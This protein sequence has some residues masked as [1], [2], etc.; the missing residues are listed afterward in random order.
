MIT[1]STRLFGI[2]G[3]PIGHVR[4]PMVFNARF[5]RDGIDAV[6]LPFDSRPERFADAVRGL[7][8]LE[9]LGGFIV[10]APHKQAMAALC[11]ELVGE[12]RLV[13]AVNTVRREPDGR[14]VGELFDG[15]G[16][17]EGLKAHG[18]D[19]AGRRLF[20][21]GAGGAGNALVFAL[22]RTGAAALTVHN[23][24]VTRAEDL[25]RRVSA[26]YP[27]CD[28][29]VGLKDPRGHDIVVNAT[30]VGLEESDPQS[31]AI[32]GL[33]RETVIAEVIMKP[34][35]TRLIRAAEA[36]GHPAQPGRQML[37]YQMDLM[38]D[39]LRIRRGPENAASRQPD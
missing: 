19:P 18:H 39:F 21:F 28:V 2:I 26:A 6:S 3:H 11:D 1:G 37:D 9:N 38:F 34:E 36:L 27:H 20:V 23:R 25:V 4:V 17:V 35:R 8:A 31:I 12:G 29:R 16:F 22:A 13:G 24:T 15:R 33:P 30:S 5:E 14:L 7:A 32:D 10:T